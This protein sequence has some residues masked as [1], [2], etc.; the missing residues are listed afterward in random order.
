VRYRLGMM[1]DHELSM[2]EQ[3]RASAEAGD[4]GQALELLLGLWRSAQ[5][6]ELAER[7]AAVGA[8][9]E[10]SEVPTKER[11]LALA[12]QRRAGDLDALLDAARA[13]VPAKVVT[14]RLK[15]LATWP[16]DP[17]RDAVVVDWLCEMPYRTTGAFWTQLRGL[18]EVI[19]DVRQLER[20]SALGALMD[21]TWGSG[22]ASR[23]RRT[24]DPAVAGVCARLHERV[25]EQAAAPLDAETQASLEAI[26]AAL[27]ARR[28][29][30]PQI[31]TG[32]AQERELEQQILA[33][34]GD[35]SLRAVYG[36]LLT[37]RGDPRGELIALGFKRRGGGKLGRAEAKREKQ[38]VKELLPEIAGPL[39]RV[40]HHGTVTVDCGFLDSVAVD[41][42]THPQAY[43][44]ALG[45]ARW[46]TVRNLAAPA[47]V[48]LHES[49]RRALERYAVPRSPGFDNSEI[50]ALIAGETP[51]PVKALSCIAQAAAFSALLERRDLF[52]RLERLELWSC[53]TDA[54][55]VFASPLCAGLK[56]LWIDLPWIWQR[57]TEPLLE[58]PAL[59]ADEVTLV[60]K[61]A[62]QSLSLV[63]TA[64]AP[65]EPG[66]GKDLELRFDAPGHKHTVRDRV[67]ATV[68]LLGRL[69]PVARIAKLTVRP[70]RKL[71]DDTQLKALRAA[72]KRFP[73]SELIS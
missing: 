26:D 5:R 53:N 14:E 39:Y 28:P 68:E 70:S 35:L 71:K 43:E 36:D 67:A 31:E 6:P 38:L 42:Q 44:D 65:G 18:A 10:P 1:A 27:A 32:L 4:L 58:L 48:V 21:K 61:Q 30:R 54:A 45:D 24:L 11:W 8:A 20:L 19:G 33:A 62:Y 55:L 7:I 60:V 59:P 50:T 40:I 41:E 66:E 52:P 22:L 13:G 72:L 25:A 49:A 51:L 17:R 15:A 9:L 3:A 63:F 12:G 64:P 16:A 73:N 29:V 57:F 56:A 34:P 23:V 47:A 37:A 69:E 46:A 2:L